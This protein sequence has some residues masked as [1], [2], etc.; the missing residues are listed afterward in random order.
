MYFENMEVAMT[1]KEKRDQYDDKYIKKKIQKATARG[2]EASW[3]DILILSLLLS[4]VL[5]AIYMIEKY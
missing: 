5:F 3:S 2:H 1:E 4:T